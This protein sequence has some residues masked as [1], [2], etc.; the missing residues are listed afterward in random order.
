MMQKLIA[1]VGVLF[2]FSSMGWDGESP[3]SLSAA[4]LEEAPK[5]YPPYPDVW[6]LQLPE[7]SE[8]VDGKY[9]GIKHIKIRPDGDVLIWYADGKRG[10]PENRLITFFGRKSLSTSILDKVDPGRSDDT[11]MKVKTSTG[12]DLWTGAGPSVQ[13][14]YN[15]LG[16]NVY[17]SRETPSLIV[18]TQKVFLYIRSKPRTHKSPGHCNE[19]RRFTVWAEAHEGGG[20]DLLPLDDGTFLLVD[21]EHGIILR[22]NEHLESRSRLVNDK[23]FIVDR[24]EFDAWQAAGNYGDRATH[25]TDFA[26]MHRDLI[27]WLKQKRKETGK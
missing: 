11:Q 8:G 14:C 21:V 20:K 2:I 16:G 5:L 26:R 13:D 24:Q 6:E 1:L 19:S 15:G 9:V 27:K 18:V 23:V 4:V 3:P 22:I 25:G 7:Y 17:L 10:N 12:L